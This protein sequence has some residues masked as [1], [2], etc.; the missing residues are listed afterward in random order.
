MSG[1]SNLSDKVGIPLNVL[2]ILFIVIFVVIFFT[3]R[4]ITIL[5]WILF[6]LAIV[7]NFGSL[8]NN[9]KDLINA[10]KNKEKPVAKIILSIV[11]LLGIVGPVLLVKFII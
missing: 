10:I 11:N 9:F 4:H 7:L 5:K 8:I 2:S 6:I 3:L 1:V